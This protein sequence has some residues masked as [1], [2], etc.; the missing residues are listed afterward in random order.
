MGETKWTKEQE[1][2]ITKRGSNLLVAAAAGS[3]K[4]AVL[5]ERIIRMITDK[6]NPVDIDKLLVVTFTNAAA[7]EMRERIGE[8]IS[9]KLDKEP[10]LKILQRQLTLLNRAN[11]TTMHS[12]CL[13]IIKNNFH[14][15]DLDPNFRIADVTE[16]IL[17]KQE[18]MEDLFED[19]YEKEDEDFTILMEC[20][21]TGKDDVYLKS[22][23]DDLYDFSMSGPWPHT[24]LREKAEDFNID[25]SFDIGTSPWGKV[26]IN[27]INLEL[28]GLKEKLIDALNI[29]ETS[30]GLDPYKETIL[31][32]LDII[33]TLII[34]SKEG[35][36]EIYKEILNLKFKTI[37]RCSKEAD[38]ES[39]K[40]VKDLRDEVKKRT[41]KITEDYFIDSPEDIKGSLKEMYVV[42]KS[43]VEVTIDFDNRYKEKKRE[44]GLLDFNDLE[45]FSLEILTAVDE[46]GNVEPSSVAKELK[47]KFS[48][49]L[50]DEYQDS[51]SV[52]ETI[53]NMVSRKHDDNPNVFMVGDVKQSIYRFRQAKPEL[54]MDKYRSYSIEEDKGDDNKK[55]LLY[56]NFRSRL[57]VINAVNYIFKKIM[58]KEVGELD[59]DSKEALNLGATFEDIKEPY[60]MV[61]GD[62]ELNIIDRGGKE[63]TESDEDEESYNTND[64]SLDEEELDKIQLEA[65]LVSKKIKALI[66]PGDG[67]VFKVYDKNIKGYRPI[68]CKDIVILMRSTAN[69]APTFVEELG[70]ESIPVYADSAAGYFQTVEVRTIMSLLQVI[71]NPLQDI[72]MIS[73]LRS[74][75]FSFTPEELIDLR[76]YN[77]EKYFY[78]SLKEI[79]NSEEE[80]LKEDNQYKYEENLKSKC[81]YV[82]ESIKKWRE[83]SI[84]D[85]ID[86]FIWY[87]YSDTSYYGFVRAMPNGAQ[88][89]AN[90]KI[91]F[92]RARQYEKT[93]YKGLFNFINF[94]NKLRKT[95][96]DMGSAKILSENEDVV[97]IMSIHK[98]KGL[99]F[100]VVI[101]AGCGK[102]FNMMDLN[103]PILF[104]EE[105]GFGPD[106]I[107]VIKRI[108]YSTMAKQSIRRKIKLETLSEEMRILYV[109]FTRAKEKLIITGS[110]PNIEKSAQKWCYSAMN[111][112]EKIAPFETIKAKTYLDWIG[113]AMVKHP[114]G[115]VLREIADIDMEDI[116]FKD[117]SMWNIQLWNK[118]IILG[119]I[120]EIK[121]E[122]D[123]EDIDLKENENI[124]KEEIE[125]RLGYIYPYAY[126]SSMPANI[127]VSD[128]KKQYYDEEINNNVSSIYKTETLK[129]PK[130]LQEDKGLSASEKGTA[131]HSVMQ[132]IDL[133]KTLNIQDIKTQ[134]NY[135][136]IK[137]FLTKEEIESVKPHKILKFFESDL[138]KRLLKVYND[139][140][141]VKRE[142][143]FYM[144]IPSTIINKDL[145]KLYENE[146]IRLQ[147][148]IDCYFEEE[149]GLVL[150]DYKTD[151]VG[152]DGVEPIKDRYKIQLK[153]YEDA[154]VKITGKKVKEKYL[155]LFYNEELVKLD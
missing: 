23:I 101:L 14:Y 65:R 142:M 95:S 76:I 83:R 51:N 91:L 26:I 74:P 117:E 56:K 150:I 87:L 88:R 86:E 98:S 34:A 94:I 28:K 46:E 6:E 93:S 63:L 149:D 35:F 151:Y 19:K 55:I 109:A 133:D 108:S 152:E 126:S 121:V 37:K 136:A 64:D 8:A 82:I 53:I 131:M 50:V 122:E 17:L 107:D 110:V 78:E 89:Q 144:D 154:L 106:Y 123:I 54:F 96:G 11:I 43:L 141:N 67:E 140:G 92:Q 127:S 100:P 32:D 111:S 59:Y 124:Y 139:S 33:E 47:V 39:Q 36:E 113:M 27:N 48:E 153:Y 10:D 116:D 104:H 58:S 135:L 120:E 41:K 12:F 90:L 9:K 73:V 77:R 84:H 29:C 105:L 18:V 38:K 16:A 62:V 79:A 20:Y 137:E 134:L 68:M 22:I 147:G 45:H 118:D 7:S 52:Q 1:R 15:I 132:H 125:R 57:E 2:A 114:S 72:P 145:P 102:N 31:E 103:K 61:G 115:N 85:S 42:M 155:Y 70:L 21:T 3:G 138:G 69:F 129:K 13:D 60:V 143:D 81:K 25:E 66:N 49:V 44:R 97:R 30:I 80:I 112:V 146:K 130:F 128:L 71:D 40:V 148:I 75:I 99:E 5:V 4:T 119:D 24:W